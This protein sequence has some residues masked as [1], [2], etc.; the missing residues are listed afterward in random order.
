MLASS[1][2]QPPSLG[3]PG[4][5]WVKSVRIDR[6]RCAQYPVLSQMP[7]IFEKDGFKFFFYSNEPLPIHIHVRYG[8]G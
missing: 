4:D 6:G 8:G 2:D 1:I 7:E 5:F 3:L